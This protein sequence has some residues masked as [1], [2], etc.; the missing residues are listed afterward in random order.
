MADPRYPVGRFDPRAEVDPGRRAGWIDE[1]AA[2]PARLREAVAGLSDEQL[3]TPYR[4]GGWTVRQVVHH[5]PDSHVNAY[6]RVKLALTEEAPRIKTYDEN[7]ERKT[8]RALSMPAERLQAFLAA[9]GPMADHAEVVGRAE[10][11]ERLVRPDRGEVEVAG[12]GG[13]EL[14]GADRQAHQH[15]LVALRKVAHLLHHDPAVKQRVRATL[16]Q[17]QS[18]RVHA[19]RGECFLKATLRAQLEALARIDFQTFF[20]RAHRQTR[21]RKRIERRESA[22]PDVEVTRP[23]H[24]LVIAG[25]TVRSLDRFERASVLLARYGHGGQPAQ[26]VQPVILNNNDI[27]DHE[28]VEESLNIVDKEKELIIRALRKNNNRRKYAARD[29]GIS[30]RTLYRKI[31]QYELE[32]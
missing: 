8:A 27:Q 20:T 13:R 23:E 32:D 19:G 30:E 22:H 6:V 11:L 29:L 9:S 1:V 17:F 25:H 15:A 5:L 31:K 4:E 10:P 26:T 21:P 2:L 3:D 12:S 16:E 7:G 28:E 18:L 14:L 24:R